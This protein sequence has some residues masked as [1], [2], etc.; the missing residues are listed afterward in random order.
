MDNE[1]FTDF[2]NTIIP[3]NCDTCKNLYL[4]ENKRQVCKYFKKLR[5]DIGDEYTYGK[6]PGYKK[7]L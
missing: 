3:M 4:N 7:K 5:V 2:P 1:F 6:C